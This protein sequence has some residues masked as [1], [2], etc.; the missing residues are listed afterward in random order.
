[1][2]A[3]LS[4]TSLASVRQGLIGMTVNPLRTAL[5]TLGVIIGVGSVIATLALMDGLERF[6]REQVAT[7]TDL[8][9]VVIDSRTI[10]LRDGFAF[11]TG[12]Y[13]VF[14][15]ADAEELQRRLAGTAEVTLIASGQ[16]IVTSSSG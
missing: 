10:D 2:A 1:M 3:V 8:Q 13:P 5:S 9:S 12:G 6:V 16:A 7:Q 15:L 11:P 14:T 4:A